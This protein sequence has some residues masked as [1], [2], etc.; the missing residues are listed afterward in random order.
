MGEP[1]SDFAETVD[2]FFAAHTIDDDAARRHELENAIAPSAEFHGVQIVLR[3]LDEITEGFRG[4][5][6]LVRTSPVEQRR[7]WLRFEWVYETPDGAQATGP[8][9]SLYGGAAIARLAP[10]GLLDLVVPFLGTRP[11]DS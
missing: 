10:D 8:D 2:R 4:E 7:E 5:N 3:G 1:D 11:P 9:G 6:R